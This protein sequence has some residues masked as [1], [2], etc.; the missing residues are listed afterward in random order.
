MDSSGGVATLSLS[1]SPPFKASTFRSK[2]P[3]FVKHLRHGEE[4]TEKYTTRTRRQKILKYGLCSGYSETFLLFMS[5][6][7]MGKGIN[8]L[9]RSFLD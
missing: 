5:F 2:W 7:M 1:P 6:E 4:K 9:N 3:T 8:N